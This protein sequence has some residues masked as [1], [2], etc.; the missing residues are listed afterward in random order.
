MI[1]QA[2]KDGV[3]RNLYNSK[4]SKGSSETRTTA[5]RVIQIR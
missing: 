1:M 5:Q 4:K 3:V 2:G